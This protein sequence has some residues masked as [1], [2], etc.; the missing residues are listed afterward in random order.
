M[1]RFRYCFRGFLLSEICYE[2]P[3][4]STAGRHNDNII[5]V[6]LANV[7]LLVQSRIA[8]SSLHPLQH[9]L[10]SRGGRRLCRLSL[11]LRLFSVSYKYYCCYRHLGREDAKHATR[12]TIKVVYHILAFLFSFG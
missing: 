3:T 4:L 11:F 12:A 9:T 2:W 10:I 5:D 8:M 6:I 7:S 1:H